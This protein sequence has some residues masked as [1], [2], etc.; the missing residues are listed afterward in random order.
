M[1]YKKSP[2]LRTTENAIK[3][4]IPMTGFEETLLWSLN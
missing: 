2:E 1:G 3:S 4:K